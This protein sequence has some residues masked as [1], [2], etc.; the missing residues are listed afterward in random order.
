M[1]TLPAI[2]VDHVTKRF[3]LAAHARS[4]KTALLDTLR[5]KPQPTL[6]ALDDISFAVARGETLGLIGA[7]G[8]GKSTLLS[9]IAGTLTPTAGRVVTRGTLS[10]LLE[11]GAGFHP[12]LTGRENVFLYGAIMGIPRETM[13]RR[14]GEIVEFAGLEGFM[15]QPVRH[16]SSGMY[17]RLGFA[18]AVQVD[19]DILLID[20]VLAVGDSDFQAKCLEKMAEFRRAGK[21]MLIISHDMNAIRR[22]SDRIAYLDHGRLKAI[23]DPMATAA[24]YRA[25]SEGGARKEWGSGEARLAKVRFVDE[26]GND[27]VDPP[28]DEDGR[29]RAGSRLRVRIDYAAERPLPPSV[30]GF[31]IHAS[32]GQMAFG[33][34][35]DV[36]SHPLPAVHPGGS[37]LLEVDISTLHAGKYLMSFSLHSRDPV[38]NYHRLENHL[39]FQCGGKVFDGFVSLPCRFEDAGR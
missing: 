5:R 35:T 20:E 12:D 38:V 18:V 22:T 15:D 19:P 28:R 2:E 37:L 13:A 21:S 36:E 7:N 4:L 14:Y 29:Y 3:V 27:L 8:A 23:G 33:S 16:Y 25:A 24:R 39:A 9:I 17:V 34:N 31:S 26:A 11:L 32:D 10:S 1:N 6:T 30:V